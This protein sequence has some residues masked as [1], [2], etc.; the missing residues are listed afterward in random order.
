[1]RSTVY[2][3]GCLS[4]SIRE[5]CLSEW[6]RGKVLRNPFQTTLKAVQGLCEL[7]FKA[8]T[9]SYL[10]AHDESP[11]SSQICFKSFK[12]AKLPENLVI[13]GSSVVPNCVPNETP[14]D[15]PKGCLFGYTEKLDK[16]H[17]H[18]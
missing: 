9:S 5:W 7:L 4:I 1:M 13:I 18:V 16:Y 6:L 10:G 14:D 17:L 2:E 12:A 11:M 15:S 3:S 8:L